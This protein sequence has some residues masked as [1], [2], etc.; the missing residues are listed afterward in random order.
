MR[1]VLASA[2]GKSLN[3]LRHLVG[4][5]Q[6]ELLR[7]VA[8]PLRVAERLAGADAQQDVVRVRVGVAQVVHVVGAD[9]R[10]LQI[11]R[12]RREAAVDEPLLLDAV[13]LHLEEEVVRAEDVAIGRR[14]LDRLALLLSATALR[15]PR[16]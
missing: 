16:P 2:S 15:P 4:G 11:A 10:Q 9:Q 8:Q 7:V 14:R 6:E 5:L 3:D 1:I 13:P 12:D